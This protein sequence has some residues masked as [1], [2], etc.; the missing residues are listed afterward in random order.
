MTALRRAV[1]LSREPHRGTICT[2]QRADAA[3]AAPRGGAGARARRAGAATDAGRPAP[4][5]G[6]RCP[7]GR[8]GVAHAAEGRYERSR[9]HSTREPLTLGADPVVLSPSLRSCTRRSDASTRP[10]A[11][12]PCTKRPCRVFPRGARGDAPGRARSARSRVAI[13]HPRR[14]WCGRPRD[15]AG[16]GSPRSAARPAS[17]SATSTARAP[18]ST[19]SRRSA[20]AGC[21]STTTTTAGSTSSWSTA[22]RSPIRRSRGR[23]G[24]ACTGIAATARSRTSPRDPAFAI[25]T[26]AWAPARAT[27]T[28]TAGS[29]STSPTSARTSCTATA[30]TASSPM[31]RALARVGS[32]LWSA[33]C[34]FADLDRDGDLDLFVTNYVDARREAQPLLRQREAADALLLSSAQLRTAAEH[35]LPQRRQRRL[36]GRQ[37]AVRRRR[38][39]RQRPRRRHRRLRR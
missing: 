3:R 28:T 11:P 25:A 5:A 20:R 26:T 17:T 37:R 16:D 29:I 13:A 36:L 14:P 2:G 9:S 32:P 34:A 19:W 10:R 22:G 4:H 39:S 24:T 38:A 33:S 35:R 23:R 6:A 8:G 7:E 27:T 1:E 31:S 21:S 15:V 18:T 12:G 30:A